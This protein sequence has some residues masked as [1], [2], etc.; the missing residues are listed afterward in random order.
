[1]ILIWRK[2]HTFTSFRSLEKSLSLWSVPL[3]A[4]WRVFGAT[5]S[6]VAGLQ[7]MAWT[8]G[9]KRMEDWLV[10]F[11][12]IRKSRS[13]WSVQEKID[14]FLKD[15]R[16]FPEKMID[17]F[18]EKLFYTLWVWAFAPGVMMQLLNNLKLE[19]IGV[20][21][22]RQPNCPHCQRGLESNCQQ[23]EEVMRSH[24]EKP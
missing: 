2:Q 7:A 15:D 9:E 3:V 13:Q 17:W 19:L 10:V 6:E 14:S 8:L 4:N 18:S 22:L 16:W 5:T 23:A 1:M 12:R 24:C 11:W 20:A 21:L